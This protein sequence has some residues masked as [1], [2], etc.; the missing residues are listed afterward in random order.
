[1]SQAKIFLSLLLVAAAGTL[2]TSVDE[3]P[4]AV[5]GRAIEGRDVAAQLKDLD[6]GPIL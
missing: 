3:K 4:E 6:Q 5:E 1:M 2:A